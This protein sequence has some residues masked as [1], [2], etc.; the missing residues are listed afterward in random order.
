VNIFDVEFKSVITVLLPALSEQCVLS[1]NDLALWEKFVQK[2]L[3]HE[4]DHVAL[5]KDPLF[6]DEAMK[7][8]SAL[9][10]LTIDYVQG[11]VVDEAIKNAVESQTAKIGHD[12][13]ME[14]KTRNDEYDRLTEHGMKPDMRSVFFR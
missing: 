10:E 9:R 8:I 2:L 11:M 1:E 12:L 5:I 6:G 4:H 13:I 14:I 7:K 3:E